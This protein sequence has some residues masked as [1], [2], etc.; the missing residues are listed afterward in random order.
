MSI[1][2]AYKDSTFG[3]QLIGLDARGTRAINELEALRT[4]L[5][6]LKSQID[7]DPDY[8]TQEKTAAKAEVDAVI[9]DLV[10]RIKAF[11]N[12]L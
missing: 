4:E 6:H 12:G 10:G 11:A 3:G 9:V 7:A 8:T 2:T 1:R 5:P